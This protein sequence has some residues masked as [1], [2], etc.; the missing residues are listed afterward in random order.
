MD[1]NLRF[2][3]TKILELDG[4]HL[5]GAQA[6]E[7]HEGDD[8]KIAKCAEAP[9]KPGRFVGREWDHQT[10]GTLELEGGNGPAPPATAAGSTQPA[11][12]QAQSGQA[13]AQQEQ[14]GGFGV[15]GSRN[16]RR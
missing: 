9:P 13:G 14:G 8:G 4:Q 1:A 5:L 16:F 12:E 10:P 11:L 15:L 7:E 6:I 2:G 3:Q